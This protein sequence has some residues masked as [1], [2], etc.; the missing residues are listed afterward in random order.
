MAYVKSVLEEQFKTSE[1][2]PV[3]WPWRIL[4][5]SI[6]FF[7]ITI[8]LYSGM[9]FGYKPYLDSRIKGLDGEISNLTKTIGEENQ[10]NLI[11]FYSQLVNVQNLLNR[12]QTVSKIFDF[13][14]KNT[15]NQVQYSSLNL[16]LAEKN[17]KL[18]GNVVDYNILVKQLEAFRQASEIEKV[19][20]EDSKLGEGGIHF[21]IKLIL[22]SEIYGN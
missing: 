12:H 15:N 8:F 7:G 13:L 4:V 6:I 2:M 21:S 3:E 11:N 20:L 16:S 5:F 22:K 18:E 14:E 10:K 1:R 9:L 17:L 19:F